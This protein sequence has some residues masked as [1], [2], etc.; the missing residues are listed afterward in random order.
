MTSRIDPTL[1]QAGALIFANDV[2][3]LATDA[4]ADIEDLQT[5][6]HGSGSSGTRDIE[7]YYGVVAGSGVDYTTQLVQIFADMK[8]T[9]K[10]LRIGG[11]G[12]IKYNRGGSYANMLLI[13]GFT[14]EA[15]P[16]VYLCNYYKQQSGSYMGAAGL[17]VGSNV[18]LINLKYEHYY[19]RRYDVSTIVV[20]GTTA[21]MTVELYP[22][23]TAHRYQVGDKIQ[24][25]FANL[26]SGARDFNRTFIITAVTATTISVSTAGTSAIDGDTHSHYTMNDC[27]NNGGL[28]WKPKLA[29]YRDGYLHG[30]GISHG[31]GALSGIGMND[32]HFENI[33]LVNCGLW[34]NVSYAH[35]IRSKGYFKVSNT[36]ADA[37]NLSNGCYDWTFEDIIISGNYDDGISILSQWGAGRLATNIKI[38]RVFFEGSR[39]GAALAFHGAEGCHVG[40]VYGKDVWGPVVKFDSGG[41]FSH[42]PT[43]R[44]IVEYV[45]ANTCGGDDLLF[46]GSDSDYGGVGISGTSSGAICFWAANEAYEPEVD[47]AS[48]DLNI[49]DEVRAYNSRSPVVGDMVTNAGRANYGARIRK[50]YAESGLPWTNN[51]GIRLRNSGWEFGEIE[52][53]YVPNEAIK[54]S[55]GLNAVT[56]TF[57]N[58]DITIHDPNQTSLRR[59]ITA[60]VSLGAS[61]SAVAPKY[62]LHSVSGLSVGNKVHVRGILPLTPAA[63]DRGRDVLFLNRAWEISAISGNDVTLG[64][65]PG[66]APADFSASWI[67]GMVLIGECRLYSPDAIVPLAHLFLEDATKADLILIDDSSVAAFSAWVTATAYVP[68]D[69]AREAGNSYRCVT[70]HTSGTFATDLASGYWV[71]Q[72]DIPAVVFKGTVRVRSNVFNGVDALVSASG[73]TVRPLFWNPPIDDTGKLASR[74]FF[75]AHATMRGPGHCWGGSSTVRFGRAAPSY[76]RARTLIAADTLICVPLVIDRPR[77][78]SELSVLC[79]TAQASTNLRIYLFEPMDWNA[80]LGRLL[81]ASDNISLATDGPKTFAI[82][83]VLDL[84]CYWVGLNTDA[85]TAQIMH[86]FAPPERYMQLGTDSQSGLLT[87]IRTASLS[88]ATAPATA[89]QAVAYASSNLGN[90]YL[91]SAASS[92]ATALTLKSATGFANGNTCA[93]LLEDGT[94][95]FLA[96]TTAM[97]SVTALRLGAPVGA[98]VVEDTYLWEPTVMVR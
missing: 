2:Q 11:C 51:C 1:P 88:L 22:D 84:G 72:D 77:Q 3:Q 69:R 44:N 92:G 10:T 64:V 52:M 74:K 78:V 59:H 49:I 6:V 32:C 56:R 16:N 65:Y 95:Q 31:S 47:S 30:F 27:Y 26:A 17:E 96:I 85:T 63:G 38:G 86:N 58:G 55:L 34:V 21:V 25:R 41:S 83:R 8:D 76:Q 13:Q 94:W 19:R 33:E 15:S 48:V 24:V 12:E 45:Q 71:K 98:P 87:S 39:G 60:V 97:S 61:V 14:I 23:E 67:D 28:G 35:N 42:L 91:T 90:S 70:Q 9:G 40:A 80:G 54:M 79:T 53:K 37:V 43:R 36:N 75:D 57:F 73:T 18:N 4:K 81:D 62:T 50:L 93:I 68:S 82:N 46:P 89:G 7:S 20:T 29:W 5:Y 66:G